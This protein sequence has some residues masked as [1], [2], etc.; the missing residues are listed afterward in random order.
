MVPWSL[1]LLVSWSPGPLVGPLSFWCYKV[2]WARASKNHN[3]YQSILLLMYVSPKLPLLLLFVLLTASLLS[4]LC[5]FA[6][7]T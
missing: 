2:L 6:S 4:C 1:A 3:A 7:L 5:F